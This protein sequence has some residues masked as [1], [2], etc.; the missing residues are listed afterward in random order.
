MT[1]V[2]K[3]P[4]SHKTLYSTLQQSPSRFKCEHTFS[5]ECKRQRSKMLYPPQTH[6]NVFIKKTTLESDVRNAP[7]GN[8][9]IIVTRKDRSIAD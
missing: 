9:H 8:L 6:L 5:P 7:F 4:M 3:D 1:F 2:W